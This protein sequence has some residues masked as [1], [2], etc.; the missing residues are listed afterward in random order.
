MPQSNTKL[1]QH[2]KTL[3]ITEAANILEEMLLEAESKNLTYHEFL[4]KLISYEVQ[5]REVKSL[6]RCLKEAAFSEQNS[7]VDFDFNEHKSLS[8]KQLKLL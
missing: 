8:H 3:H 7:L 6:E 4:Y 1:K 5:R 2:M